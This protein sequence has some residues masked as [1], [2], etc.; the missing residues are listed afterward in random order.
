MVDLTTNEIIIIVLTIITI[1]LGAVSI[2][3]FLH[4]QKK[5]KLRF[6]VDQLLSL[7]KIKESYKDKIKILYNDRIV[8]NLSLVQLIIQNSGNSSISK[9]DIKVPIKIEFSEGVRI[10]DDKIISK[11]PD[12]LIIH[13]NKPRDNE[14][15]YNFELLNPGN[16]IKVQ[17]VCIGEEVKSP[18]VD[19]SMIADINY[20]VIKYEDYIEE[21]NTNKNMT[22]AALMMGVG[23][24]VIWLG[25]STK[26]PLIIG[27]SFVIGTILALVGSVLWVYFPILG[28]IKSLSTWWMRRKKDKKR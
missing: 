21:K 13:T 16:E 26:V 1:V 5:K 19:A 2:L 25:S 20:D 18:K 7:V 10:I 8:D 17:F 24:I 28:V 9:E 4:Y 27:F 11:K 12:G 6:L 23:L 22:S 14:I 15:N 3:L